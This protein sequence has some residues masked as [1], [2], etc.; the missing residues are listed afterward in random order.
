VTAVLERMRWW[1]IP[2]VR[3]IESAAFPDDSWSAEQFWQELA[4]PTRRYLV[5]RDVVVVGYAGA[6]VSPPD[7]DIQTIAVRADQQGRG[8]AS[9]LLEALVRASA[10]AGAT[11]LMLEVRADNERALSLY[12]R[13]GFERISVRRRYYPDGSD[14][15]I[16]RRPLGRDDRSPA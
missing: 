2:E 11:H 13:S 15:L 12:L 5:A 6:F 9:R 16:M 1:D 7:A 4:Q 10:D 14:A 8:L 3:A